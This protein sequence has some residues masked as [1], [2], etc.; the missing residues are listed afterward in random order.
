[1]NQ[2]NFMITHAPA[3]TAILLLIVAVSLLGFRSP[4]LTERFL[5]HPWMLFRRHQYERLVTSGF[6]HADVVHLLFNVIAM[7]SVAMYVEAVAGTPGFLLIYFGSL[8]VSGII[9]TIRRRN[10]P[11][12]RALGASGAVSALFFSGMLYFPEAKV[13]LIFLPIPMPWPVFALLFIAASIYG[14]RKKWDNVA[15]DVHIYGAV[16]GLLLTLALD[17]SSMA[18]FVQAIGISD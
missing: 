14:A 5:L 7:Y 2:F 1:M 16:S 10:D 9:P 12:Y 8:L 11:D 15:H 13:A 6:L 4:A 17:P 3:S 18:R